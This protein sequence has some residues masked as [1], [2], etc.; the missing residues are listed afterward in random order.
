MAFISKF[1]FLVARENTHTY[2]KKIKSESSFDAISQP[3]GLAQKRTCIPSQPMGPEGIFF[4]EASGKG[5]IC[6]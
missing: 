4:L 5:S 1:W 6:Y 2:F 3:L